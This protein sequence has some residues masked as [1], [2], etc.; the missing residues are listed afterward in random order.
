M[1]EIYERLLADCGPDRTD[2]AIVI[3]VT[4]RPAGPSGSKVAPPSYPVPD[5]AEH[6]YLIEQRVISGE[7]RSIVVLDSHQSQANRCEEALLWARDDGLIDLPLFELTTTV[8]T[9]HGGRDVR[10]TSLDLPHRYADAYLRDSLI[11]GVS[12]DKTDVG[13]RLRLATGA[14]ATALFERDPGSIVY[15]AWD[16]HRKGRQ[17]KFAR[18]YQSTV[19]GFDPVVGRRQGGRLDPLNLTGTFTGDV[20]GGWSHVADGEK[21]DKDKRLSKI[22]HG[23]ALDGGEAHGWVT[24]DGACRWAEVSLAGLER[25]RFGAVE[26]SAAAAG[27]AALAALALL[28]DRLAFDRPSWSLRSGC[29]LARA[30]ERIAWE[31]PNGEREV[32]ELGR[33]AAVALFAHAVDVAAGRGLAMARDTISVEPAAG[34]RDAIEHAYVAAS[35]E[36]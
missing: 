32:F 29:H 35:A 14:D 11:G 25:V 18:I 13:K 28:G 23:S 21:K 33:D 30:D 7:R 6:P 10:L 15:G 31:R 19:L 17:A 22:G 9:P 12:F 26:P 16:S 20:D 34:L 1:N 2:V 27:R 4:A 36:D 5:N 3:D 8:D 24:V